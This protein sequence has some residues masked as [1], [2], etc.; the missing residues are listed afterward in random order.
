MLEEADK[1]TSP[2]IFSCTGFVY[3]SQNVNYQCNKDHT[4]GI[5]YQK[6]GSGIKGILLSQ[7]LH[8][9]Y[10][11]ID[12]QQL[13]KIQDVILKKDVYTKRDI[14]EIEPSTFV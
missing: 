3:N 1:F 10:A 14:G 11:E 7:G 8:R 12:F 5:L 9:P 6:S 13:K 4:L 2:I